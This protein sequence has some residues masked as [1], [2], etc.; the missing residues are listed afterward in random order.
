MKGSDLPV[1]YELR[2]RNLFFFSLKQQQG[3]NQWLIKKN[4][5]IK[6]AGAAKS[7]QMLLMFFFHEL[8][9]QLLHSKN[10]VHLI[11]HSCRHYTVHWL[12]VIF[13]ISQQKLW[14]S[15]SLTTHL[16]A[17]ASLYQ[18][19]RLQHDVCVCVL[20]CVCWCLCTSTICI[21]SDVNPAALTQH[22]LRYATKSVLIAK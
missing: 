6:T 13:F 1:L 9:D 17:L 4:I 22:P 7:A 11:S 3:H 15:N 20:M 14:P 16:A 18:P 2:C 21:L 10:S 8:K 5:G 12:T 19:T